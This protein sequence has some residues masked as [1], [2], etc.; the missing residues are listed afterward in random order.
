MKIAF[1]IDQLDCGGAEQQLVTLSIGLHRR[2]HAVHV[3]SI[4]DRAE[5]RGDLQSAG[6]PITVAHKHGR[7]DLT[8]VWRLREIIGKF[9]PD[10]IHAYLPAASLLTPMTRWLGV[11]APILLSERN[12]NEWRSALRVACDNIVRRHAAHITCNAAAIKQY[13]IDV[14]RVAPDT[15]SVIYNG[16]RPERRTRPDEATVAAARRQ[17]DA[18][19]DAIVVTCVANLHEAKQ[20]ATL[21]NA[22]SMAR[23]RA[24]HLF[25]VVVGRGPLESAIRT[26]IAALGLDN[27]CRIVTDCTNPCA[28]LSASHM[29]VLTSRVEGC[30]NAVLEAMAMG[31]PIVGSDGGGNRELIA[32]ELGGYLC[33]VGDVHGFADAMARLALQP[34]LAVAMGRYNTRIIHERFSDDVMVAENLALYQRVLSPAV[35]HVSGGS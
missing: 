5:L 26:Q 12:L 24:H 10:L 22:F 1:V 34:E 4:Y 2:G 19:P 13:L 35:V 30:S 8:T 16:L 11:R 31:L 3:V 27:S 25:L 7:F 9:D 6:V 23:A 14:E 18:P 33:P 21:V 28:I 20:H 29:A 15:I 32:H 17:I